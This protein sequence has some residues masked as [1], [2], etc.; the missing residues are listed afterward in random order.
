MRSRLQAVPSGKKPTGTEEGPYVT[1]DLLY[2]LV[3]VATG[4]PGGVLISRWSRFPSHMRAGHTARRR[5]PASDTAGC[6]C[7]W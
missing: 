7:A 3:T 5:S 1:Y 6:C 4:V 2:A